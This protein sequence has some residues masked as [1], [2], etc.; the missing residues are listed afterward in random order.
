MRGMEAVTVL[1]R[2]FTVKRLTV[3]FAFSIV[4]LGGGLLLSSEMPRAVPDMENQPSDKGVSQSSRDPNA[5]LP[6]SCDF[7]LHQIDDVHFVQGLT[8]M[9]TFPNVD[10]QVVTAFEDFGAYIFSRGENYVVMVGSCDSM[11]QVKALGYAF[12]TPVA[13]DLQKRHIKVR[14][15]GTEDLTLVRSLTLDPTIP[16]ACI[17]PF[18]YCSGPFFDLAVHCLNDLGLDPVDITD[19]YGGLPH[20]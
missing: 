1:L 16:G 19:S 8:E 6:R 17:D 3:L 18:G 7:Y 10:Q 14:L 15:R 2:R 9:W 20:R 11:K 4:L 13:D 12:R 5:P